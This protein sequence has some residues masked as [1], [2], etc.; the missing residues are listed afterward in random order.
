MLSL[1]L[2]S[3]LEALFLVTKSLERCLLDC[4][5]IVGSING[6]HYFILIIFKF[7]ECILF[8]A[9]VKCLGSFTRGT[10]NSTSRLSQRLFVI[11]ERVSMLRAKPFIYFAHG[12]AISYFIA[13][14]LEFSWLHYATL[15]YSKQ[16]PTGAK[17]GLVLL[18]APL[19][20]SK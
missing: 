2:S 9:H 20:I 10:F 1:N 19:T 14:Y 18:P 6:Y 16:R 17:L 3:A 5:R 12:K 15:E 11:F 13:T 7:T 8:L 4:L